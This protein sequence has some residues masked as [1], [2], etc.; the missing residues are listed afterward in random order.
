MAHTL[1]NLRLP[2][3]PEISW[4][5]TSLPVPTDALAALAHMHPASIDPAGYLNLDIIVNDTTFPGRVE[6]TETAWAR[7]RFNQ[8]YRL[9]TAF[10]WA[11]VLHWDGG[12]NQPRTLDWLVNGLNHSEN[13][14]TRVEMENSAHFGVGP[15]PP[16]VSRGNPNSML[17]I[18]QLQRPW[19]D[20][21][22]LIAS[23]LRHDVGHPDH[24]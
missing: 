18:A 20:G 10:P 13:I 12:P 22:P 8:W 21:T 11:I 17:S 19:L 3:L 14:V 23:H 7:K 4:A 15:E 1:R 6:L 9:N 16:T 2:P 5:L 24:R